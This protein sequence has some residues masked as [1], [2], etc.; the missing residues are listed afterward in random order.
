MAT[1]TGS[2]FLPGAG[3]TASGGQSRGPPRC[4]EGG[5]GHL[6]G[7]RPDVRHR[8]DLPEGTARHRPDGEQALRRHPVLSQDG[9]ARG[10]VKAQ[11]IGIRPGQTV[12]EQLLDQ[13]VLDARQVGPYSSSWS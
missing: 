4:V 9:S 10:D 12:A 5:Q 7:L 11:A 6:L 13:R 8:G 3:R 1:S 2:F